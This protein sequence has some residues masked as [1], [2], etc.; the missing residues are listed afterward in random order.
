[1]S[2][3]GR[4]PD[5]EPDNGPLTDEQLD[6]LRT[7]A[8]KDLPTGKATTK[9]SLFDPEV[10]EFFDRA[11]ETAR[12][13][14]TGT[15]EPPED[16]LVKK[17]SVLDGLNTMWSRAK[18][19]VVKDSESEHADLP[20]P[21][22]DQNQKVPLS[23]LAERKWKFENPDDTLK[24]QRYLLET[25]SI[26]QLPWENS[27][28]LEKIS[29]LNGIE[30]DNA[31]QRPIGEMKGFGISFPA[32][33]LKG[34]MFLRVDRLPSVL[35]KYNGQTWIEVDKSL[36]DNHAYDDA[37]IDH[38]IEKIGSGEYDPELLS[39]AERDRIEQKLKQNPPTA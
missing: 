28:F 17:K 31:P 22:T 11:R 16:E 21:D 2:P 13:I 5:Y 30:A 26:D 20:D 8:Q 29:Q 18:K 14:D 15:Y 35:F 24:H 6:Q 25:G 36:S 10:T 12:A 19:L 4:R 27:E 9:E 37:Y 38:L 33:P 3:A 34:D 1:M 23:K 7:Q 32:N 39:N